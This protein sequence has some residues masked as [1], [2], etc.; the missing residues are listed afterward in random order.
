LIVA[1]REGAAGDRTARWFGSARS[2]QDQGLQP[3]IRERFG[4]RVAR[5]VAVCAAGQPADALEVG[6]DDGIAIGGGRVERI[7]GVAEVGVVDEVFKIRFCLIASLAF[8]HPLQAE[9]DLRDG[10][11]GGR[12]IAGVGRSEPSDDVWIRLRLHQV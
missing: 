2:R 10:D 4:E 3:L 6:G 11:R 8:G 5:I 9:P 7:D 1:R 12:D